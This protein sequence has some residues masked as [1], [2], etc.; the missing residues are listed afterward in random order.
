MEIIFPLWAANW[1]RRWILVVLLLRREQIPQFAMTSPHNR[2]ATTTPA[3]PTKTATV[4][5]TSSSQSA[6]AARE[7]GMALAAMAIAGV[8]LAAS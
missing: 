1:Q 6:L 8:A 7:T 3:D 5:A 4:S 2:G